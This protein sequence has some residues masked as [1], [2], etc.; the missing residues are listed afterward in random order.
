VSRTQS[1]VKGSIERGSAV[2]AA[3]SS[4]PHSAA[5]QEPLSVDQLE[6]AA[7]LLARFHQLDDAHSSQLVQLVVQAGSLGALVDRGLAA[8]LS[9]PSLRFFAC[10][11]LLL[12]FLS[13]EN[14]LVAVLVSA[15]VPGG[16]VALPQHLDEVSQLLSTGRTDLA[17]AKLSDAVDVLASAAAS[18]PQ[19][20][21]A[22][23]ALGLIN[24]V[25][26]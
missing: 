1:A 13:Y 15:G 22:L 17:L 20:V 14:E 10:Y 18:L 11:K 2:K 12:R 3:P 16:N 19:E 23:V 21:G 9:L 8:E 25:E 24:L 4:G 5:A 6:Q 26:G 7:T